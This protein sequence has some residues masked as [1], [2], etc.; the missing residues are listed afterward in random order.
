M[1]KKRKVKS[2]KPEK[3]A[4]L[5]RLIFRSIVVI[6]LSVMTYVLFFSGLLSAV[7]IN[8][9]GAE[10]IDASGLKNF[11]ESEISG[12]YLGIWPK[13]NLIIVRLRTKKIAEKMLASHKEI[14][15]TEIRVMFPDILDIA[16]RERR[17][18]M[19]LCVSEGCF[20]VDENGTAYKM[21]G[22]E[23]KDKWP[24][25]TL[26]DR[27][28][29]KVIMD[30]KAI[31]GKNIEYLGRFKNNLKDDLD[32][33]LGNHFE[34]PSILSSDI[35]VNVPEGWKL[36]FSSD[37]SVEKET[38]VLKAVLKEKIGDKRTSLEYIDIRSDNKV[39]YKLKDQPQE[40]GDNDSGTI[41]GEEEEK[42]GEKKKK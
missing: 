19:R 24:V 16:I 37:I 39:F 41:K 7:S 38:E 1:I 6:F 31:D 20:L 4:L 14:M 34:T 21:S 5:G 27:G 22:S 13:N 23:E 35:R 42:K 15:S 29:G 18:A 9:S 8:I 2:I 33:D 12:K 25:V 11:V 3:R 40:E 17:L 10:K 26:I 30:K 36:L 28:D 32:L